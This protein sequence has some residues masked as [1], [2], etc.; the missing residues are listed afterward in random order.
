MI[1]RS[2]GTLYRNP[3]IGPIVVNRTLDEA[4]VCR[5]SASRYDFMIADDPYL[6]DLS[7]LTELNHGRAYSLPP[8]PR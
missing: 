2:D 7:K 8:R 6:N 3:S 4:I 5:R 1:T